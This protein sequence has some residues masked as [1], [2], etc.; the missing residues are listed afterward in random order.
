MLTTTLGAGGPVCGRIGLGTMGMSFAYDPGNRDDETSARVIREALDLGVTLIDTADV[1]GPFTNEE[2]VGRALQGRRDEAVLSTKGGVRFDGADFTLNGRP[3]YLR[4][5]L[6]ASLR[7]LRADHVDVYFLH[8]VDP[9]V[10]VEESWG[11]LADLVTAGKARAIGISEMTLDEVKRAQ[12]IHPVAAVQSE[13]SL[14][15][16]EF[17]G[18]V[19]PHCA[20]EGIAFLC[21]SP[22][23]GGLLAGRY[24]KPA[25]L[26]DGDF[27]AEM[28]RFAEDALDANAHLVETVRKIGERHGG[29]SAQVALAWLLAQGD[30]VIPIP[31]TK[32]YRYL[33][34][35]AAAAELVLTA[36]ELAELDALPA[37][38]GARE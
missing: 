17:L 25:D 28:P 27:R 29:T 19:V 21:H 20:A 37:P 5:A 26:A 24:A 22:I 35:N 38:V 3:E 8:R 30:H 1:Y 36:D 33:K 31:G 23:G 4:S 32:T 6:D 12:A 13:L 15:T 18:D 9:E 16:R 14:F 10:P 11:A 7:R 2:L 34:E